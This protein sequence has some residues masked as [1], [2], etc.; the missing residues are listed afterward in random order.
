M[1]NNKNKGIVPFSSQTPSLYGGDPAVV[2]AAETAKARIQSAYI[3]AIQKPRDPDQSRQKILRMCDSPEFAEKVEYSKPIGNTSIKDLSIRFAEAA[4]AEWGNILSEVQLVYDDDNVRRI[5]VSVID[6]ET[7]T[8]FS[9]DITLKK[10][11]ERRSKRG[12]DDDYI[13]ERQNTYG[14]TVYLLRATEDEMLI[15]EG[16][17]ASKFIRTEGL[18]LL[19]AGIKQEAKERARA[20]LANRDK[21]DPGAAKKRIL[22]AFAGLNVWPTDIKKYLGH[23]V[24]TLSASEISFLRNVYAAIDSG[25]ASWMDYVHKK[26][27]GNKP[28][29]AENEGTGNNS[30]GGQP[31]TGQRKEKPQQKKEETITPSAFAVLVKAETKKDYQYVATE[32]DGIANDNLSAYIEMVASNSDNS[33]SCEEVMEQIIETDS[34]AGFWSGFLQ[35]NWKKHFEG[36]LPEKPESTSSSNSNSNAFDAVD[37][38]SN[39]LRAKGLATYYN[40]NFSDW[41]NASDI[42]QKEFRAKW[43]RVFGETEPFPLDADD[44]KEDATNGNEPSQDLLNNENIPNNSSEPINYAEKL[45]EYYEKEPEK[46]LKACKKMNYND[47]VIPMGKSSQKALYEMFQGISE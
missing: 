3:M 9:R 15:K 20:T 13:S 26:E 28:D 41:E 17:M 31:T 44:S 11:V 8:Q 27:D 5:R 39:H 37:W 46:L 43:T 22:D 42:S 47:M 1:E 45:H 38:K 19:P 29:S 40:T 30:G 18:R 12:R 23:S 2:A 14:K 7:N 16:A 33:S 4:M 36:K 6:L 35:G 32:K 21:S 34:F 24:D 25:E 10:T